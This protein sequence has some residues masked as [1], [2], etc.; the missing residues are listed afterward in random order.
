MIKTNKIQFIIEIIILI[1]LIIYFIINV[2][3]PKYKSTHGS[4]ESLL[5]TSKYKS[6]V[7][8]KIGE[9]NFGLFLDNEGKVYHL[10]FLEKNSLCLYNQYIENNDLDVAYNIIIRRLI[11]DNYL[12]TDTNITI[13][14]YNDFNYDKVKST[15]NEYLNKYHL[16]I[17]VNEETNTIINKAKSLSEETINTKEDALNELDSYSRFIIDNNEIVRE[18][19]KEILDEKIA[20]TYIN[21]IYKDI[22]KYMN[23]NDIK[24]QSKEETTLDITKVSGDE[25]GI[26][27]P[28]LN[29]YFYIKNSKVYAFIEIKDK[30]NIYS[31]CYNGSIDEYEKGECK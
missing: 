21:N 14:K 1:G 13:I 28:T 24:N 15:F 27:Y 31:Y 16:N 30:E 7:E 19:E 4:S 29:S 5:N 12:K 17:V 20:K 3:I 25:K 18:E 11:L 26:Y 9:T 8:F 6:L 22:E 2:S 23:L 10:L